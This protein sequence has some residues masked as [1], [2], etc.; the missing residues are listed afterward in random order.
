M[1]SRPNTKSKLARRVEPKCYPGSAVLVNLLDIHD[2]KALSQAEADFTLIRQQLYRAAPLDGRFDLLHLQRIHHHLFQDVYAWAGHMRG[3][4]MRKGF[5]GAPFEPAET[6]A[7]RAHDLFFQL[8]TERYLSG[9]PWERF[10]ERLAW[11][12]A[13]INQLHPFPEGNGRTQRLFVEHL[14]AEA[15]YGIDWDKV[16]RWEI[17]TT[18]VQAALGSIDSTVWMLERVTTPFIED[19]ATNDGVE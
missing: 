1:H 14:A 5:D 4:D 17:E 18:A 19:E 8:R 10:I 11:Y 2:G 16:H 9:L 7:K 6:L 13:R 15:G 3:Y 12:Y